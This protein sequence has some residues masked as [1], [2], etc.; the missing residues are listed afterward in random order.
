MST[1]HLPDHNP[2]QTDASSEVAGAAVAPSQVG[3]IGLGL[4]GTA[5]AERLLKAGFL[6]YGYDTDQ[7]AV[8]CLEELGGCGVAGLND[9]VRA[10]NPVL[11]CLPDSDIVSGVLRDLLPKLS[12]IGTI[13][14]LTTG[15]PR[16]T[17]Q[18]AAE[19]TANGHVLLDAPV[20]GSS[21]VVRDGQ[22]VLMVG[23]PA[24]E[25]RRWQPLWHAI[26]TSVFHTGPVGS[27][28][29]MKLVANLVLGLNRAALAEGLHLA[30]ACGLNLPAVLD[31]LKSGAS[32]SR[33]MDAKGARMIERNF[34]PQARLSQHLK[35]V[36]LILQQAQTA[37]TRLPLS[38]THQQLLIKAEASGYGAMD[39]SAVIQA[40]EQVAQEQE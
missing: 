21:Q 2:V 5:L 6:V 7:A 39:N 23:G 22:A 32:Y 26:S 13:I 17:T 9:L 29:Q 27:G 12:G 33:A 14:D 24:N 37:N 4:L 28:Q 34:Q 25:F 38:E 35:D 40:Y 30:S 15:D 19:L 20:L 3:L 8:S 1:S 11:L 16:T 36:R 10:A 31:I 18:L